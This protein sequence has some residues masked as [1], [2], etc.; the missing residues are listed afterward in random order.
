MITA[1]DTNVLLDICLPDPKHGPASRDR[2]K[3]CLA[4]GAVL[5]CEAVYAEL[6]CA[7]PSHEAL[8]ETL[9]LL[10]VELE[11]SSERTLW[12]AARIW[13]T[14]LERA[15]KPPE[16]RILPDFLVGAHAL[17]QA[18]RLLTRDRGFYRDYFKN[19]KALAP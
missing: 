5:V 14:A 18:D 2:L 16:R 6:A 3:E 1:V 12:E 9:E 7:F 15:G 10:G 17:V 8:R 11:A 13:K 19:L 4:Q